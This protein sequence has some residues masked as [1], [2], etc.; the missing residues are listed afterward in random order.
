MI[1]LVFLWAPFVFVLLDFE[2][3]VRGCH[4]VGVVLLLRG[5]S[6]PL[7]LIFVRLF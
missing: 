5:C 1:D 2:T 6:C 4:L 7:T 3:A